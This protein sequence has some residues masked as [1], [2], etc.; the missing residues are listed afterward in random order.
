MCSLVA[1]ATATLAAAAAEEIEDFLEA[2]HLWLP[3]AENTDAWFAEYDAFVEEYEPTVTQSAAAQMIREGVEALP[4]A[5]TS[6]DA[7]HPKEDLVASLIRANAALTAQRTAGWFAERR[8]DI[9]ASELKGLF[10][11]PLAYSRLLESKAFPPLD[12]LQISG[13]AVQSVYM[14]PFDWGVRFEPVVRKI[15]EHM[16]GASVLEM[17]RMRHPT[18]RAAASPDG[19]VTACTKQVART[20]RLL[21]IKCP[22]TREPKEGRIP[23]EYWMQMQLQMAVTGATECDFVEAQFVSAYSRPVERTGAPR[24]PAEYSGTIC[25]C[26]WQGVEAA[27]ADAA[28]AAPAADTA[29]TE[30]A[31]T[32]YNT[33]YAYGP[34]SSPGGVPWTPSPADLAGQDIPETAYV[35]ETVPWTLHRW[36]EQCVP[37]DEVWIEAVLLPKVAKFWSDVEKMRAGEIPRPPPPVKR[38]G[39]GGGAATDACL[40]TVEKL[41]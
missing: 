27:A 10:G 9:N 26:E 21:E 20:G 25:L 13:R 4:A 41:G 15:Y 37:Y 23:E 12:E 36:F 2:A 38:G 8:E 33:R 6:P 22:I 7:P 30:R 24:V 11:T 29:A 14:T 19:L 5:P 18:M 32:T 17:G 39:R 35:S 16:Y 3:P 31:L 1:A 40:I 28:P 34:V